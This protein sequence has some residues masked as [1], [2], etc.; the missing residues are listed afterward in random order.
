MKPALSLE[1]RRIWRAKQEG[2]EDKAVCLMGKGGGEAGE[3]LW[4]G[5]RQQGESMTKQA[6]CELMLRLQDT[7]PSPPGTSCG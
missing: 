1:K 3:G 6:G 4:E 2:T 5:Q 7:F